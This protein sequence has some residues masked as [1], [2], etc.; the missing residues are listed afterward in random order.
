MNVMEAMP[1]GSGVSGRWLSPK[2]WRKGA[3][4]FSALAAGLAGG[5]LLAKKMYKI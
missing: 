1:Q 2:D 5:V 4:L 3:I